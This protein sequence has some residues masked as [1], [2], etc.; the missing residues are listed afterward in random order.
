MASYTWWHFAFSDTSR[1]DD[2]RKFRAGD[3][4]CFYQHFGM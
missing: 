2:L 4:D 3:H 1:E